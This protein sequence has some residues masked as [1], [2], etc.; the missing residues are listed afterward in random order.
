V[1]TIQRNTFAVQ[2]AVL[3]NCRRKKIGVDNRMLMQVAIIIML[4]DRMKV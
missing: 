3:F 4:V 2:M 1:V